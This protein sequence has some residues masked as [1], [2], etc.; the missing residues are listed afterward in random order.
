MKIRTESVMAMVAVLAWLGGHAAFS[1]GPL[2]PPGAPA[3]TMKTLQEIEPRTAITNAGAVTLSSPGS[4][5]LTTNI[6]VSA[7]DAITIAANGVTL[8]LNGFTISSTE[9]SPAG[10]G[11]RLNSGLRD[12]T[13]LNG[14][15]RGGV[16]NNGS[17]VYGGPG[18]HSGI[19]Y[20]G[21]APLNVLI[22]GVSVTGCAQFGIYLHTQSASLVESCM[23]QSIRYTGIVATSVKGSVAQDCGLT[24]IWGDSV[25]DC[26]GQ[27]ISSDSIF[28]NTAENSSGTSSGG[29]GMMINGPAQNCMGMSSNSMGL[30]A[31]EALNCNGTSTSN[32][33]LKVSNTAKNCIGESQNGIGLSGKTAENCE[34]YSQTFVGIQVTVATGCKGKSEGSFNGV[35]ADVADN[36]WG[37]SVGAEG[38]YADTASNCRGQST[39]G[40]GMFASV[41]QNCVGRSTSGRGLVSKCANNCIGESNSNTGLDA[42]G[43]SAIGCRGYSNSGTGLVAQIANSCIGFGAT[44]VVA[45]Y[46][47]DMP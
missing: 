3:P 18:F 22:S 21:D 8:D 44:N 36:C 9:P 20:S 30:F 14:H 43:G 33:G 6:A 32:E 10:Y 38:L 35:R 28:A 11:I 1:Q 45:T 40:D 42:T 31:Y 47:Y 12:I 25:S 26:R 13:I 41:A 39:S 37:Q 27:S 5:Y 7:G 15:I 24:A 23:V 16:T 29:S 2:T 46:K 34:G 4:Y 19:F 17:G